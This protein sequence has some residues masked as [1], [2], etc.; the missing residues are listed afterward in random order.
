MMVYRANSISARRIDWLCALVFRGSIVKDNR[1]RPDDLE[2]HLATQAELMEIAQEPSWN[3][4]P[5]FVVEATARGDVCVVSYLKGQLVS[6]GWVAY[7][8]TPH[9]RG[10]LVSF[11]DNLRYSYKAFTAHHF[12]GRHLRGSYG[13]LQSMDID[14]GVSHSISFIDFRNKASQRAEIRNGGTSL[15]YA[16]Y[17][18]I[19]PLFLSYSTPGPKKY[20]FKFICE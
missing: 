20:G 9:V 13:V 17:L 16:G 6:Y 3:M 15:G 2:V 7:G 11:G 5:E 1:T 19:G 10:V 4:S 14:R 18:R 8:P 12:R